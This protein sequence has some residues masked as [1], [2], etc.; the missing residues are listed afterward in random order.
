MNFDIDLYINFVNQ[1]KIQS[2]I[3]WYWLTTDEE[4]K[5]DIQD[6][7]IAS[8]KMNGSAMSLLRCLILVMAFFYID[9]LQ[10]RELKS[11]FKISDGKLSSNL[12]QLVNFGYIKK[13][14]IQFDNKKMTLY[15]LTKEG[16]IEV[17]KMGEWMESV[18]KIL[19]RSV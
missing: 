12:K 2:V 18:L 9:G 11:A 8:E 5:D 7:F 14:A 1:S 15:T 16:Q 6:L 3:L 4:M 19:K 17:K 10:Y 13:D